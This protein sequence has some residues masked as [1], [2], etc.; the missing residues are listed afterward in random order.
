MFDTGAYGRIRVWE[1]KGRDS[2]ARHVIGNGNMLMY[3]LGPNIESGYGC[4]YSSPPFFNMEILGDWRCAA[5]R[6]RGT[7]VW[8]YEVTRD[9]QLCARFTDVMHPGKQLFIRRFETDEELTF[10][11][12]PEKQIEGIFR[13]SWLRR[14]EGAAPAAASDIKMLPKLRRMIRDKGID[15]DDLIAFCG[16]DRV[17]EQ[18]IADYEAA[19]AGGRLG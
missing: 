16:K 6:R 18:D 1:S 5:R 13:Q 10:R 12:K 4:C 8:D 7:A 9:G 17:T 3:C 14:P 19:R 15:I 2:G 11:L